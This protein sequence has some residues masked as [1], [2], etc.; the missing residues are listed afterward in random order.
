[1][2]TGKS[3]KGKKGVKSEKGGKGVLIDYGLLM[4]DYWGG[5][6]TVLRTPRQGKKWKKTELLTPTAGVGANR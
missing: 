6:K 4:I 5:R 3:V 2:G 1:M